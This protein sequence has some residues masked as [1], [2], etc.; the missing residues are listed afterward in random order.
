[1]WTE[2]S[3]FLDLLGGGAGGVRN[4]AENV[5]TRVAIWLFLKLF[6]RNKMVWPFGHFLAFF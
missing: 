4:N 5:V 3:N 1:M 6:A 2:N